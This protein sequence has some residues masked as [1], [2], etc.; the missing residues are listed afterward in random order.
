MK[1]RWLTVGLALVA[2]CNDRTPASQRAPAPRDARPVI[3][4]DAPLR[5]DDATV[6]LDAA[7]V[8]DAPPP[9]PK[10]KQGGRKRGAT[11][12]TSNDCAEGLSCS[13]Y[14]AVTGRE[15]SVCDVPCR[16][17]DQTC[18]DGEVCVRAPDGPQGFC[19]PRGY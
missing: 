9:T 2:A 5:A 14:R 19:Q 1:L 16:G 13:R 6:A 7:P 17:F 10:K 15:V 3:T 12:K 18:P 11:C 4:P 8:I